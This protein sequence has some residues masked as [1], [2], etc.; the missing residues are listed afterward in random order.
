MHKVSLFQTAYSSIMPSEN[1][2]AVNSNNS[3]HQ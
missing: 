2:F 3:C 1:V